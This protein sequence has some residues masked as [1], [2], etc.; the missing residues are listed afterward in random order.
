MHKT[1]TDIDPG[2]EQDAEVVAQLVALIHARRQGDYLG[3]ADAH[4]ELVRLGVLVKFP[5]PRSARV[6]SRGK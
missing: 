5:R 4:R 3:A 1:E 6:V 2:H